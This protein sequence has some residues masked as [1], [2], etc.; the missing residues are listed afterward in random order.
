MTVLRRPGFFTHLWLLWGLR[1]KIAANRGAPSRWWLSAAAFLFSSAPALVLAVSFFGLMQ[2]PVVAGSELW[3]EFIV[4]LLSFVTTCVWVTWPVLSAGVDDH[5]ELSRYA[6][7]PI[8]SFRLMIASTVASLFEPR[9]LVFYGPLVGAALGYVVHRPPA[10]PLV[11]AACFVVYVLFNAALSRVGLHVMLNVLRQQR[12]AELLGGGFALTLLA[13]SFIPPVDTTWLLNLG[14]AG[15]EA[16]PDTLVADA[17][18]ALGRFPT[19]YF[20]HALTMAAAHRPLRAL[21]DLFW[22]SVMLGFAL[23]AAWWLLQ[24]FHEHSGRTGGFSGT[25]RLANPFARTKTLFSTLVAREAVDLW[26]NPRARLL[27]AVPFV[28]GILLKLLSGRDLFVFFLGE[29]ADAWFLGGLCVYGAIV[30]GS[31]FSQNAFAYDGHGFSAFLSAPVELGLVL[32]AKNLVHA[33]SGA[34]LA[35]AAGIFYV[36][37]FQAGGPLDVACALASVATLIPVVLTAGNFLSVFFP[38][39]FHANLKRRDKLPFIASMLGVGAAGLGTAPLAW[40]LRARGA[41]GPGLT[42]LAIVIGASAMAWLVYWWSLPLAV[43]LLS[44]R[45]EQVLQAVTRE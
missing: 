8:S 7:F 26:H 28:L 2:V 13:A 20:A 17:A 44:R 4:R 36:L 38:V 43:G 18:L 19:G 27:A 14:K 45:R 16:V 32:K 12:S 9:A 40:A 6:A 31:T 29:T 41:A 25:A 21:A 11:V 33:L 42:T 23:W 39:K 24:R 34:L 3:P 5:S 37:Y 22:L 1:L 15:V 10:Y 30:L 35:V